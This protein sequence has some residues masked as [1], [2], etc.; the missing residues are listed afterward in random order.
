MAVN[1]G[2]MARAYWPCAVFA[3]LSNS[4]PS[5]CSRS[6]DFAHP[7]LMILRNCS[8]IL[9]TYSALRAGSYSNDLVQEPGGPLVGLGI[10]FGEPGFEELVGASGR[11][12]AP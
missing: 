1:C 8:L 9:G 3:T 7:V 10:Q 6:P 5:D 4:E 2:L 12:R 11:P